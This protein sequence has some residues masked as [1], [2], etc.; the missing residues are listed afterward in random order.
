MYLFIIVQD[1]DWVNLRWVLLDQD[2]LKLDSLLESSSGL[3]GA[4][5]IES[6][7]RCC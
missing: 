1:L 6:W 7:K 5:R 2:W 4:L 3:V